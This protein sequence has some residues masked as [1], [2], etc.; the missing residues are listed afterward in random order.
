MKTLRVG[1]LLWLQSSGR[2]YSLPIEA[3][4]PKGSSASPKH[5][6]LVAPFSCRIVKVFVTPGQELKEGDPV[7]VIEAMKMETTFLSPKSGKVRK[8][9]AKAGDVVSGGAPFVEWE[10]P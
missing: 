2:I 8:V 4:G 9:L 7:L 1:K 6:E 3:K 5:H 10:N